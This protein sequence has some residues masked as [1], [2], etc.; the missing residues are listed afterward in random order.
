MS[1]K[2]N[3]G[4]RKPKFSFA[5]S[6]EAER[7]NREYFNKNGVYGS[8]SISKHDPIYCYTADGK[9]IKL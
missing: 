8:I 4:Y 2:V 5:T 6:D 3:T 7:F 1:Y 9:L